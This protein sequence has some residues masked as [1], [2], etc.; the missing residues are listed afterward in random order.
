MTDR[1]FALLAAA[2]EMEKRRTEADHETRTRLQD[3]LD[4]LRDHVTAT[5]RSGLTPL[6]I[7]LGLAATFVLGAWIF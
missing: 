5:A 6:W 3:A 2:E 4:A 1:T 7:S